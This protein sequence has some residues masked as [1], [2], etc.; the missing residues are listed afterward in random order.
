VCSLPSS[1]GVNVTN[2]ILRLTPD[3]PRACDLLAEPASLPRTMNRQRD[4]QSPALSKGLHTGRPLDAEMERGMALDSWR[5]RAERGRGKDLRS[6]A[7]AQGQAPPAQ[8]TRLRA[9]VGV[10]TLRGPTFRAPRRLRSAHEFS[11]ARRRSAD[12]TRRKCTPRR[13][14]AVPGAGGPSLDRSCAAVIATLKAPDSAAHHCQV[15]EAATNEAADL[16]AKRPKP[17]PRLRCVP[18]QPR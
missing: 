7:V 11:A 1:T 3:A 14:A 18:F 12:E 15:R 4:G 16:S 10:A 2:G 5:N 8:K 17:S 9:R 6:R 13:R